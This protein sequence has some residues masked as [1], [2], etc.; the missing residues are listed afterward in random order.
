MSNHTNQTSACTCSSGTDLLASL[1]RPRY[2][3]GQL[4]TE[5]ELNSEQAYVHAKNRLHNRFLHGWG[6]VCGLQV[7]CH[8]ECAG[9][10]TVKPGYALDPC[11]NDIIVPQDHDFDVLQAINECRKAE[12]RRQRGDCRP[13]AAPAADCK[14][15]NETWC[16][17]L[18]YEEQEARP[19]TALRRERVSACANG[20]HK[21]CHNGDNATAVASTSRVRS[22]VGA[23]IAECEPTRILEGYRLGLM[24]GGGQDAG[25]SPTLLTQLGRLWAPLIDV[26]RSRPTG[27][28]SDPVKEDECCQYLDRVR[29]FLRK[30]PLANCQ[31][32][33]ELDR[34]SCAQPRW[35]ALK[36][37]DDKLVRYAVDS[38]CLAL[39]PACPAEPEENRLILACLTVRA[40]AIVRICH[41]GG[42]RQ[43]VTV[44]ALDYWLAELLPAGRALGDF[45][46]HTCCSD[47]FE[48]N[49]PTR[50]EI[51]DVAD[52][53]VA[54]GLA[55]LIGILK[56]A[57]AAYNRSE[58][59]EQHKKVLESM[60][61]LIEAVYS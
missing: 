16:L 14:D 3:S 34:I 2:F 5:A 11:G 17:T 27:T 35:K 7:I 50:N 57:V 25:Q 53:P 1:E 18:S 60:R 9:W 61:N 37:L 21:G 29:N 51:R 41:Y 48:P 22:G 4:L 56:Q 31:L 38:L 44:P 36:D 40:G 32:L 10:V 49:P 30:A 52:E 12:R 28:P 33:E 58:A 20:Q 26:W 8:A 13:Y 42:R 23:A 24:Q 39:L 43:V 15:V 54:A 47:E 45:L 59:D 19:L 46:Q 55:L 6:V